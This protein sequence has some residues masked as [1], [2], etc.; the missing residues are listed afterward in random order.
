VV[1]EEFAYGRAECVVDEAPFEIRLFFSIR[2]S[3]IR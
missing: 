2:S 1:L 3:V